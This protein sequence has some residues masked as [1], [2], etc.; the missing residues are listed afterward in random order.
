ARPAVV[1]SVQFDRVRADEG[2]ARALA[3]R[4]VRRR[5]PTLLGGA[6]AG[7]S[8][9]GRRGARTSTSDAESPLHRSGLRRGN[10]ASCPYA[11]ARCRHGRAPRA[12]GTALLRRRLA[13]DGLEC[14]R[15]TRR[16]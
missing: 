6:A 15:L 13:V 7:R 4:G 8:V 2:D 12:W 14:V 10:A 11:G 3:E 5:G 1:V 9:P 16:A